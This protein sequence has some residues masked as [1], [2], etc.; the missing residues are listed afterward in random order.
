MGHIAAVLTG[1]LIGSTQA[2]QESVDA[3][4]DA[5]RSVAV[6]E[7]GLG[8]ADI[9]FERFRGDGWQIYSSDT[10]R[11][12]RLTVRVLASLHS[13]P[14]LPKTRISAAT[15][16]VTFLSATGLASA[17][18]E[19]FSISGRNLDNIGR[20]RLVY[21]D[22]NGKSLWKLSLFSY[23]TWQSSRWSPEQAEAIAMAFRFDAPEPGDS[24]ETLRISRQA[25][26][27]RLDGAGYAPLWDAEQA[28][29]NDAK[30]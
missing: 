3:A 22:Q 16:Q 26:S 29:K 28:F 7:A 1:D 24:A 5:I 19:V 9:R 21:Q 14:S 8:G 18:G 2:E 13:R 15:G 10:T 17:S 4:M 12:F 27:A 11:V 23:L 30:D 6:N 25:F 20:S